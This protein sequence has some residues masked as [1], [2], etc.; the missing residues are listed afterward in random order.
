MKGYRQSINYESAFN[1]T[2]GS[3]AD[4]SS[5][6]MLSFDLNRNSNR[7]S[8]RV[9]WHPEWM[10]TNHWVGKIKVGDF[11]KEL[12]DGGDDEGEDGANY[13]GI[14]NPHQEK[15]TDEDYEA[16]RRS[17]EQS[18]LKEKWFPLLCNVARAITHCTPW[19]EPIPKRHREALLLVVLKKFMDH[20]ADTDVMS[21]QTKELLSTI[22][23]EDPTL[24]LQLG[25]I[26]FMNQEPWGKGVD[27]Y[28][29]PDN[30]H[31]LSEYHKFREECESEVQD[32]LH[33]LSG[34][35]NKANAK[36]ND[37]I[38]LW[39]AVKQ[40][41]CCYGG[42]TNAILHDLGASE[43]S[44][45]SSQREG[46]PTARNTILGSNSISIDLMQIWAR[47][48]NP[49]TGKFKAI[50]M[51]LDVVVSL[52]HGG[53]LASTKEVK[54]RLAPV[55]GSKAG[56]HIVKQIPISNSDSDEMA[57]NGYN[58][59]LNGNKAKNA[60]NEPTSDPNE[61]HLKLE[62]INGGKVQFVVPPGGDLPGDADKFENIKGCYIVVTFEERKTCGIFG[63][64][65]V[66]QF[67][68]P[69]QS[70]YTGVNELHSQRRKHY[71]QKRL[72]GVPN[73]KGTY[74]GQ[75]GRETGIHF[76]N[77]MFNDEDSGVSLEVFLSMECTMQIHN[78]TPPSVN[79]AREM[80]K[81]QA[82]IGET[83][84]GLWQID[85]HKAAMDLCE[86]LGEMSDNEYTILQL[87]C[88]RFLVHEEL[89]NSISLVSSCTKGSFA[90]FEAR[91]NLADFM[92][93]L[94][95]FKEEGL[96]TKVCETIV[97]NGI[98]LAKRQCLSRVLEME[99]ACR[100]A[101][102]THG[103]HMMDLSLSILAAQGMSKAD[104]LAIV[105]DEARAFGLYYARKLEKLLFFLP[106]R[107][108]DSSVTST[109]S[110]TSAMEDS[111][112]SMLL[113]LAKLGDTNTLL[114]KARAFLEI[115]DNGFF[116]LQDALQ[117]SIDSGDATVQEFAC[118]RVRQC[119]DQILIPLR[120]A[121]SAFF[122]E[123]IQH[124]APDPIGDA[125]AVVTKLYERVMELVA[126][127]EQ[128][129]VLQERYCLE[130]CRPFENYF[131][132]WFALCAQKVPTW[133]RN[134]VRQEPLEPI[135]MGKVFCNEVPS[136]GR[137]L[138]LA[139]HEIFDTVIGW[140]DPE[141]SP[142]FV[143]NFAKLM[144]S[145]CECLAEALAAKGENS[146]IPEEWVTCACTLSKLETT[147]LLIW[148][149][150]MFDE[151]N[152][153]CAEFDTENSTVLADCQQVKHQSME[154]LKT[155]S[156][157]F[158]E[159]VGRMMCGGA[160]ALF[161]DAV[162]V[163]KEESM[164]EN[165]GNDAFNQPF[166]S[167][168][169]AAIR[170][171]LKLIVDNCDSVTLP[172][173]LRHAA[174][175]VHRAY[176][177]YCVEQSAN[178]TSVPGIKQHLIACLGAIEEVLGEL[179]G[180]DKLSPDTN[181]ELNHKSRSLVNIVCNPTAEIIESLTGRKGHTLNQNEKRILLE[182]LKNRKDKSAAKFLKNLPKE[183]A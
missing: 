14:Y 107:N 139:V 1:R 6:D 60:H 5:V 85:H 4:D 116:I 128:L 59:V 10:V 32:R 28:R 87:Y 84:D 79:V 105:S 137:N 134:I 97:V 75:F 158:A 31:S 80:A 74:V 99:E 86:I 37:A 142:L 151:K 102:P 51:N 179:E 9:S 29:E 119:L 131:P 34:D 26:A 2:E 66:A 88:D 133:T 170:R 83:R 113:E 178:I 143:V 65:H 169:K 46:S 108:T 91:S 71:S 24:E 20:A 55:A 93:T 106:R 82:Q 161:Q 76:C 23:N 39:T 11:M 54:A 61:N 175:G 114:S 100:K 182:T 48:I 78:K 45:S 132:T 109:S 118:L 104:V 177:E 69:V 50:P 63:G 152:G 52:F 163:A 72:K 101:G 115:I 155:I 95:R 123:I 120:F 30:F 3:N 129:P 47:S 33:K 127:V 58:D 70:L 73:A 13:N 18:A 16:T 159:F 92:E 124:H 19:E 22:Q 164:T 125:Y 121:V 103:K 43:A 141:Q 167:F 181:F 174:S 27:H 149:E 130:L 38:A 148:Q 172:L 77:D 173:L 41:S 183:D 146:R 168:L 138:W 122:G 57:V 162:A 140:V 40:S 90:D 15:Q 156:D 135:A 8:Y 7:T 153:L 112:M 49:S 56:K 144:A 110:A 64:G 12:M 180:F 165:I 147:F 35:I 98:E 42:G 67:T 176:E 96:K 62:F 81:R 25:L 171:E 160:H 21:L 44:L 53:K 145:Y 68:I 154:T 89:F 111:R 157:A 136:S 117:F 17:W 126:V 94:V 150:R 36:L 166:A